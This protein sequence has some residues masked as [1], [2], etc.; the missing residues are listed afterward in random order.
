MF[1]EARMGAQSGA[2]NGCN[3][4]EATSIW[5]RPSIDGGFSVNHHSQIFNGSHVV[6]GSAVYLPAQGISLLFFTARINR[7][8]QTHG[9][10]E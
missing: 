2:T 10:E 7:T 8:T 6:L 4:G 1:A 9:D 3:S 5:Q